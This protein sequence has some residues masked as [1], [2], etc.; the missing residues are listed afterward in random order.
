[1]DWLFSTEGFPPRWHCGPGFAE[2]PALGW[3]LISANVL[4]FAA[5]MGFGSVMAYWLRTRLRLPLDLTLAVSAFFVFCGGGHLIYAI[6]FWAPV[7]RFDAA[8]MVGQAA[9]SLYAF[10][11]A[12]FLISRGLG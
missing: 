4:I 6:E 9:I 2:A 3:L 5:Y 12:G 8:W 10:L 1:M 11:R 7:Y